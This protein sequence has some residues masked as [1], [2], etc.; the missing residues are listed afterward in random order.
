MC[1]FFLIVQGLYFGYLLGLGTMAQVVL[2]TCSNT[3]RLQWGR[4]YV[5]HDS[6]FVPSRLYP[7]SDPTTP[8]LTPLLNH[9]LPTRATRRN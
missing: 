3:R 9:L 4:L 8:E 7:P 2:A 6:I 5:F 1:V